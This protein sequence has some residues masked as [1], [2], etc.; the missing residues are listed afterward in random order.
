MALDLLSE[1]AN[2]KFLLI[3]MEEREYLS[4]LEEIMKSAEKT[5]TRICYVCLNKPYDDVVKDLKN[6]GIKTADFFF[7]DVLTSHYREA[8]SAANCIFLR[9]PNDLAAMRIAI[10][11][12]VDDKKCS[13]ILFDTISTLLIYQQTSSVIKFTH[14][15]LSDNVKEDVKKLF[16]LLKHD[17]VSAEES[18]KLG[19]DLGMFADKTLD[20]K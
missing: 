17:T 19:K 16:I 1:I 8:A 2:N 12:A 10:K 18:E 15:L 9:S 11:K 6:K 3:L 14:N 20:M 4:K 7:I 13:V 5:K